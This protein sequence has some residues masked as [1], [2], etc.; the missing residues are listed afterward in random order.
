MERCRAEAR[1]LFALSGG[2]PSPLTAGDEL[3]D[4]VLE[5]PEALLVDPGEGLGISHQAG[6]RFFLMAERVELGLEALAA[7]EVAL[8]P[9]PGGP[10]PGAQGA[11]CDAPAEARRGGLVNEGRGDGRR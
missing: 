1:E 8:G 10:R 3:I 9:P 7:L 11:P 2:A 4:T 6:T 5:G